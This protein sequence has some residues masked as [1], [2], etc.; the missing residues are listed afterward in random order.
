MSNFR[1]QYLAMFGGS[2][3]AD[4]QAEFTQRNFAVLQSAAADDR[5]PRNAIGYVADLQNPALAWE[6]V[7]ARCN[8]IRRHI[9]EFSLWGE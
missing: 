1:T 4:F 8:M 6:L 5:L 3:A 2:S 9:P 7:A